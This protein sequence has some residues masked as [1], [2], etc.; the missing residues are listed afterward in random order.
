M[1]GMDDRKG[2]W[3]GTPPS[4]NRNPFRREKTDLDQSDVTK[5][6]KSRS[7]S[8]VGTRLKKWGSQS[9]LG[10]SLK[11]A[12]SKLSLSSRDKST[13]QLSVG[14]Q[15]DTPFGHVSRARS[16]TSITGMIIEAY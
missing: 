9:S 3:L 4:A 1:T 12:A 7:S 5:V 8:A 15:V 16:T 6:K 10:K 11:R 13:S 14:S 2:K